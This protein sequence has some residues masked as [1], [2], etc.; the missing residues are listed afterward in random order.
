MNQSGMRQAKNTSLRDG[1]GRIEFKFNPYHDPDNGRFTFAPGAAA[2]GRPDLSIDLGTGV[3]TH[4]DGSVTVPLDPPRNLPRS[5]RLSGP[6]VEIPVEIEPKVEAIAADFALRTGKTLTIVSG[7]RTSKSQAAA[8]YD[9]LK[10]GATGSDYRNRA[11][12]RDLRN[13]YDAGLAAKKTRQQVIDD[14]SSVIDQ[15][16]RK[17][18]FISRH[19]TGRAVDIRT[20]GQGFTRQQYSILRA[21]IER[22]SGAIHPEGRPPHVHVQF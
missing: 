5:Y 4:R 2:V 16:A 7:R 10:S 20:R 11:A 21:G 22:Q 17:G 3:Q 18:V 14:M 13:A 8:M 9:K 19:L 12:F 6:H 15:Q 1:G